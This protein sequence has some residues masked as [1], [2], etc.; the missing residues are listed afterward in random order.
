[1]TSILK[2]LI[3]IVVGGLLGG[4]ASYWFMRPEVA[5]PSNPTVAL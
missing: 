4:I 5:A 2:P 3:W 1:M